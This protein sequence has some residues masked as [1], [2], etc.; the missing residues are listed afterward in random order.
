MAM[1]ALSTG[2][3]FSPLAMRADEG[4]TVLIVTGSSARMASGLKDK[5]VDSAI[6]AIVDSV[7]IEGRE[8]FSSRAPAAAK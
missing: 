2:L 1:M 3:S 6:I 7:H 5:P 4:D 8:R